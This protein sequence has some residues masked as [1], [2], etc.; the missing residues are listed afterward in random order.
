MVGELPELVHAFQFIQKL[1]VVAR[2]AAA[3]SLH[4]RISD[5]VAGLLKAEFWLSLSRLRK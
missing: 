4:I 2:D 1:V 5:D 3:K